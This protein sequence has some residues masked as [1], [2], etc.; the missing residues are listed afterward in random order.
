M[1]FQ[2]FD[3]KSSRKTPKTDPLQC[4]GAGNIPSNRQDVLDIIAEA[5]A[6]QDLSKYQDEKMELSYFER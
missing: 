3:L 5:T 4:Y 6:R 1:I 2:S